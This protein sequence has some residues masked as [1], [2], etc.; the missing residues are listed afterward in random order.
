ME[1]HVGVAGPPPFVEPRTREEQSAL[2]QTMGIPKPGRFDYTGIKMVDPSTLDVGL[3]G[4]EELVE[5]YDLLDRDD[6]IWL[7]ALLSEDNGPARALMPHQIVPWHLPWWN[8]FA[9][10]GGRGTGKTVTGANAVMEMIEGQLSALGKKN[11]GHIRIAVAAP[12]NVSARDICMEGETGLMTLFGSEF[13]KYN[14]TVGQT[15]AWHK[16]GA[17]VIAMGTEKARPWNGLQ[18]SGG[19][20][21]EFPLC[22]PVAVRD[23]MLALRLGPKKG[24]FRPR[25]IVTFTPKDLDWINK[26]LGRDDVY[27]PMYLDPDTGKQRFPSTFDNPHLPQEQREMWLRMYGGTRVGL[28]ELYGIEIGGVEGAMWWPELFRY[29]PDP[30]KWPRFL[31]IVVAI[32]PAGT[33]ARKDAD[34]NAVS[35]YERENEISPRAKTAICVMGLGADGKIYVLAWVA[36]RWTPNTWAKKAVDLYHVFQ[37][38]RFV[39]ERNFG[40]LMVEST[41]RNV[42]PDA[43]ISTVVASN[44]KDQRAEPVVALYEQE[45]MIH[46]TV[47]AEGETQCCAFKN[48]KENEGADLV[49]ALVWGT[50][51]LMGWNALERGVGPVTVVGEQKELQFFVVH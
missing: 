44:G 10:R 45:R 8:V 18:W 22:N 5:H 15:K 36:G 25:T 32:D 33:A 28:R 27:V 9:L 40:G 3:D 43:P 47:F 17:L 48:A 39:A 41:L 51:E 2:A 26:W 6:Q 16:S 7:D 34:E 12:T 38:S 11:A 42:W 1:T 46:A 23:F 19:W 31:R 30:D 29:E 13:P 49:D 21:D 50:F 20:I 35:A 14:K 4:I 37:A 24:P